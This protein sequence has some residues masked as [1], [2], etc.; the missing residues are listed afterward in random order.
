MR[1][2]KRGKVYWFDLQFEGKR[3]QKSTKERNKV[4][5][6]GIAAA[7]RTALA[8][9]RVGIVERKPAPL[10]TDAMKAFL[11][12]SKQEHAEHPAT[13]VRYKTSSKPLLTFLKFKSKPIDEITPALIEDYKTRRARQKGKRTK[14]LIMPATLNRELACLKAMFNHAL[15]DRHAFRNPVS[16]VDFLAENNE[17]DRI[18]TFDEQRRYLAAAGP[19]LRDI[20]SLILETGM[21]PEEV[22]RL[23]IDIVFPEKRHVY[24]PFG[25]T[26]AARRRI[27]LNSAAL[28]IVHRRLASAEGLYL[29]PHRSDPNRTT[30]KASNAHT[31][32][33]DTSK[34]KPRFRLYDLR[35]TWATRA[36]EAGMDMPTLGVCAAEGPELGG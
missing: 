28:E 22:Y 7:F 34:I 3:Y 19:T 2:F 4:K 33:L 25:K 23:S 9:R 36:A 21:R 1:V 26:K 12:W 24:I 27:P 8:N 29:F 6:E 30:L 15:K 32:A 11:E 18:L 16:D 31:R 20:A 17:Q 14:R 5:A 13:Y 10:L 35:H